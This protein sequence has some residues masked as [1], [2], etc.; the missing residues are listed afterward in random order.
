MITGEYGV[1]VGSEALTIP[2]KAFSAQVAHRDAADDA[3]KVIQSVSSL[4]ELFSYILSLPKNSFY[5]K[6]MDKEMDDFLKKGYYI[7]SNIPAGY[8]IGSSGAVS[9]LVYDR[10]FRKQDELDRQ[11]QRKDLATIESFFHGKSSGVDALSCYAGVP[12]H[13]SSD[14]NIHEVDFDPGKIP[15][16]YRLFLLDTEQFLDTGPLVA[17]FLEKMR[18][19]EFRK[20]VE[21]DYL[22]MISKLAAALL[23][24]L[25]VDP[26][27][28]FR[29]ISDF[30]WNHFRQMIP[31][32][33]EDAWIEGQISNNYYLKINGSGG[34]YMLGIAHEDT[35]EAVEGMLGDKVVWV[36]G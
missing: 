6:L 32:N 29:M 18:N 25:Q 7:E 36:E 17:H 3:E 12:L 16:G 24:K 26:A 15:G 23:G 22:P 19:P 10:F 11:H 20:L 21:S 9:A 30:Q 31:E 13:F 5:A 2:L 35:M 1:I 34:G 8:S 4:R 14:G 27:L 28:L 33:M